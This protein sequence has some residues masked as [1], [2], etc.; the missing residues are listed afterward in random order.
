MLRNSR[1]LFF[2]LTQEQAD[3]LN[4]LGFTKRDGF[5]D[6]HIVQAGDTYV[7]KTYCFCGVRYRLEICDREKVALRSPCDT[8]WADDWK[9]SEFT[10]QMD[11]LQR[12]LKK[13]ISALR[14]AKIIS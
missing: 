8:S 14:R 7:V 9:L 1:A 4:S 10:E 5:G 11:R 12:E 6:F 2:E 3:T 13:D